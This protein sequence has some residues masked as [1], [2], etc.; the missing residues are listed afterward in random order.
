[1]EKKRQKQ[2]KTAVSADIKDEARKSSS[3]NRIALNILKTGCKIGTVDLFF[4]NKNM[5][6]ITY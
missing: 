5:F 3:D 1:M 6:F 4:S 2:K